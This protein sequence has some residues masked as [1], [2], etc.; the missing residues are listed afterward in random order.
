LAALDPSVR[1]YRDLGTHAEH[2]ARLRERHG[3]KFSFWQLFE[4][5]GPA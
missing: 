2:V 5:V 3:R 4:K 1:D